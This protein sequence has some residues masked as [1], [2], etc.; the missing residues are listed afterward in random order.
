[1]RSFFYFLFSFSS[2]ATLLSLPANNQHCLALCSC[3]YFSHTHARTLFLP[4]SLS[5]SL[6]PPIS[7][8]LIAGRRRPLNALE[9]KLNCPIVW[10][11]TD[12]Q[13]IELDEEGEE[14]SGKTYNYDMVFHPEQDTYHLY[15]KQCKH[16]VESAMKGYNGTVFA[17]GQT[18][19]GKTWT[20]MGDGDGGTHPGVTILAVRDVFEYCRNNPSV[21]WNIDCCYM[22]IYNETITDLLQPN[23]KKAMNLPIMEDKVFGPMPKGIYTVEVHDA[24]HCLDVLATGETHR[25][26]ASTEMNAN[27]SRSHTLFRMRIRGK[28]ASAK[29]DEMKENMRKVADSLFVTQKELQADRCSL[30]LLDHK[31]KEMYIQ[32]GDI[33]LRLPIGHGIAGTVGETGETI[34]IPDAYADKRFNRGVDQKTGY[35]TKSIL[36]MAVRGT[37]K[38]VG[39][40]QYINKE[41][42][43]EFSEAD[44]KRLSEM[45]AELGPLIEMSQLMAK[46]QTTSGLNLVDLA[47]SERADKSGAK[48]A[49]LK[50]GA[51]INKSLMML[52]RC[53]QMLSSGNKGHVPFRNSKLTRLLS[54]SLGGNA[55][56]AIMCAFSPASRNRAETIS[57]FQFASRAK[58]IVNVAK[59]NKVKD[60]SALSSAYEDEIRKLKEQM[61]A[62]QSS[63]ISEE[64]KKKMEEEKIAQKEKHDAKV[65]Y[66]RAEAQSAQLEQEK[67]IER[68]RVE[69]EMKKEEHAE[70]V[71]RLRV[72]HEKKAHHK[73]QQL[74]LHRK[75]SQRMSQEVRLV[76]QNS[77][78]RIAELVATNSLNKVRARSVAREL[79][80]KENELTES[81]AVNTT[82][83]KRIVGLERR[84]EETEQAQRRELSARDG[85]EF[86][87]DKVHRQEVTSR[88]EQ[89]EAFQATIDSMTTK[90][91]LQNDAL[92]ELRER[93]DA[94]NK[95]TLLTTSLVTNLE[96]ELETMKAGI[97]VYR[98]FFVEW[99]KK[100]SMSR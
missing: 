87:S 30:F 26:F 29:G 92:A 63:G 75:E 95:N 93:S 15:D 8:T 17:Y 22:E 20:L 13:L 79:K 82:L 49:Q 64:E 81:M 73:E 9:K 1:M 23:R 76:E 45:I 86:E 31:M 58:T 84:A 16:I 83:Q 10:E 88:D 74:E 52:G 38:I 46:T 2:L 69:H 34:N 47:G 36:C 18:S 90:H 37:K 39:V 11:F 65:E 99:Q 12:T 5:P 27:S 89:I 56:T 42:D 59:C 40:V 91:S 61:M 54:T 72:L 85:R 19:S 53:I 51:N 4:L 78:K 55:K 60:N 66:M 33:T 97:K 77:S 70:E 28:Y 24:K 21:E 50:E 62:A 68:L 48:G 43:G 25:S 7:L 98:D 14:R 71:E 80:K 94:A 3:F 41:D 35:H 6:S 67:E 32:A 44:E 100:A 57:T 96:R